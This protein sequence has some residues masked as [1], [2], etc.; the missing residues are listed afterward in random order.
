[1]KLNSLLLILGALFI[2]S[3]AGASK[4]YTSEGKEGYSLNCSGLARNWGMCYEKAGEICGEKGYKIL[5]K[6]N[7]TGTSIQASGGILQGNSLHF[8]TMIVQ[9]KE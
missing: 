4:T 2:S 3:C 1:M 8:R 7:Q 6:S 9:C 5:E